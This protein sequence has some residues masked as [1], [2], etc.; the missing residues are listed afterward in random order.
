[1]STT[2]AADVSAAPAAAPTAAPGRSRDNPV[3]ATFLSRKRLNKAK[4]EKETWHVEF[5]L[6]GSGI[7]YTVGDAFGLFPTNDA[8]LADAVI[9]ALGVSRDHPVHGRALRDVLIND[10]SLGA[11]P[12]QL[13]QLFSYIAGGDRRQKAK[14]LADGGDPDGDA[15]TLDV[16]AAIEKF[17]G[18]R[19]D[20]EAFVEVLDPLQPRLYSIASSP[21]V[22]SNRMALCVDTVRYAINGRQ[23]LGV[24]STFLAGRADPGDRM[25]VY[26]QKAHAFGLP[27]DPSVPVIMIGPGTGIAPFR[28]FLEERRASGAKGKNWLFFGDQRAATDFLYRD[29][30]LELKAAGVLTRLDTAFSRDQPEKIYVQQRLLENAAELHAWL[31]A[32]AHFYVCGDAARMA[33]DVDAALHQVVEKAS[34]KSPETAA[35]YVQNLKAAKRY[36]RDVY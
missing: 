28:A 22:D 12:D 10:V 4:S 8:A 32:G 34:G 14:A 20:P 35:A 24:A 15:A 13:F 1:L 26:V 5:D 3:E 21:K 2:P 17:R 7:D 27:A 31:E 6:A 33:R 16:L 9:A 19:P 30:L 18:L 23:R 11:A 29:E 25:K 36:A